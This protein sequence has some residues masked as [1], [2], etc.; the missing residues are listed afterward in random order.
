MTILDEFLAAHPEHAG[1]AGVIDFGAR[2]VLWILD[3]AMPDFLRWAVRAKGGTRSGRPPCTG[4]CSSNT[5]PP[6]PRKSCSDA[7][8]PPGWIS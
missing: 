3:I 5:R 1:A 6:S 2:R 4:P 8:C 7:S